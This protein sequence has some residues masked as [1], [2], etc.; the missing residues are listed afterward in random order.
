MVEIDEKVVGF[1][2]VDEKQDYSQQTP[3]IWLEPTFKDTY[4][5]MPHAVIGG[6]GVLPEYTKHGFA[7]QL[8]LETIKELTTKNIRSIFS[9]VTTSPVCNTPSLKFHEKNGFEKIAEREKGDTFDLH[10]YQSVLLV[11]MF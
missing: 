6:I 9:L 2:R 3:L 5:S 7:T 1:L 4:F 11:N 8:F 10:D